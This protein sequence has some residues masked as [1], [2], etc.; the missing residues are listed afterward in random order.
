M[1][2]GKHI[3]QSL[4]CGE[5]QAQLLLDRVE[6]VRGGLNTILEPRE[7]RRVTVEQ[8]VVRCEGDGEI[9]SAGQAGL[10]YHRAVKHEGLKKT[11]KGRNR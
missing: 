11:C 4:L 6:E 3:H 9:V 10:I 2:D 7:R 5:F 1:I 8:G